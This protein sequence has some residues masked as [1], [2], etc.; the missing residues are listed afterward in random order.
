MGSPSGSPASA[1]WAR[2]PGRSTWEWRTPARVGISGGK[3]RHVTRRELFAQAQ[4]RQVLRLR[5]EHHVE[6]EPRGG[7]THEVLEADRVDQVGVRAQ[8]GQDD[9]ALDPPPDLA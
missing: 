8:L 7:L 3:D 2:K 6:V 1:T 4:E 5:L 9:R